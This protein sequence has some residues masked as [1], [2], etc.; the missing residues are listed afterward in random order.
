MKAENRREALED[1]CSSPF[2]ISAQKVSSITLFCS[3][4]KANG[5]AV[6]L[7]DLIQLTSLDVSEDQLEKAWS[8]Q[9][10]LASKY[11]IDGG[12]VRER[13]GNDSSERSSTR[14]KK[15][16]TAPS[17]E[18]YDSRRRRAAAHVRVAERFSSEVDAKGELLV[19]SVSGSTSY[20]SVAREDDL[21][22]F[23]ITRREIM[24]IFLCKA[25]LR[26]RLFRRGNAANRST[27]PALCLSYVMDEGYALEE[28]TEPKD[29]LFARDA[30]ATIV[31]R[32]ESYYESLLRRCDWMGRY[33]PKM[34]GKRVGAS[35]HT[36]R[37]GG[38]TLNGSTRVG[39][40]S[41]SRPESSP[42][43][44]HR[45]VLNLILYLTAGTYIRFKSFL[46]NREF[47]R[48]GAYPRLFKVRLGPDHC[49]YE[50]VRYL[51]LRKMYARMD[52]K[53]ESIRPLLERRDISPMFGS[54]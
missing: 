48:K 22:F 52:E 10:Y 1:D 21:D 19:L 20:Q 39:E 2:V 24:W 7:K 40:P 33:F 45:R 12:I 29:A 36:P 30:L 37:V 8:A 32:G 3:V 17:V 14:G 15:R 9:P 16:A 47:E 46:L 54:A 4:A 41:N 35:A 50:S 13:G 51:E 34:Y 38:R 23:C 43:A 42:A 26:A 31:I 25:L 53:K 11:L 28:F 18:E 5:A 49:I 27:V 44:V 6:S